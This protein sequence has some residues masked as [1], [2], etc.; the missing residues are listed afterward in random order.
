VAVSNF[1]GSV[2]V[3]LGTGGGAFAPATSFPSGSSVGIAS[4]DFNGDGKA[5]LA[6]ASL[7]GNLF[8]SLGNGNGT[9][10]PS[11]TYPTGKGS[12]E[13][14]V[15]DFNR[16]GTPDIAVTNG[17]GNSVS[18]LLGRGDGTFRP[19]VNYPVGN[20]PTGAGPDDIAN[21]DLNGDGALD[22]VVGLSGA[23]V[24]LG[25]G[26]GTF[27]PGVFYTIGVT[28]GEP[29]RLVI[30]D[31]NG[32][33]RT[34]V[35]VTR[36]PDLSPGAVMV[37]LGNGDG[38]LQT[39]LRTNIPGFYLGALASADLNGD[40]NED[41]VVSTE[42]QAG[43]AGNILLLLSHGDG[44]FDPP[45]SYP[46]DKP[47]SVALADL[48]GAGSLD[49]LVVH[50]GSPVLSVYLNRCSMPDLTV[51]MSHAGEFT[52]GQTGATYSATMSNSGSVATTQP[53]KLTFSLP[54]GLTATALSGTG[55][56]CT[57]SP[58]A[59]TRNDSLASGAHYPAATLQVNVA[60]DARAV[61]FPGASV[62]GGGESDRTNDTAVDRTAIKPVA[63]LSVATSAIPLMSN[64]ALLGLAALLLLLALR[65]T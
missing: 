41:I 61:L 24:L 47:G 59:C 19:A 43:T 40:G 51:S 23:Q 34:D 6:V 26:D 38:T 35:A 60:N 56:T 37:L 49:L 42:N 20:Y 22:L 27:R 45:A 39:S 5:D 52:Q 15:G 30:G 58:L 65:R 54:S 63:D 50:Y 21:V 36:Y 48:H 55:W 32:D 16:D 11:T 3:L 13:L 62:S 10:Q 28:P 1:G 2:S 29:A 17:Y 25:N 7:S 64:S 4:G 44:T 33:G 18:V 14:T 31:F 9:F 46:T 57:L 53:A 8:V 12:G